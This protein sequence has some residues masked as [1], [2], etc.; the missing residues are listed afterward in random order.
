MING[1]LVQVYLTVGS[2][3]PGTHLVVISPVPEHIITESLY[4]LPDL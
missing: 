1:A 2:E 3:G 4:W